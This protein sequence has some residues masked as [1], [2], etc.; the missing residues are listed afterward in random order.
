MYYEGDE[1]SFK[2]GSSYLFHC[3][4]PYVLVGKSSYDDRMVR[5]NVDGTWD[6]GDLRCEGPIC[7]DP[8]HPDEGETH[9][10]SVEESAVAKFTCNRPGFKPFPNDAINCTLG[11][12]SFC[13]NLKIFFRHVF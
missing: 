13:I 5:C 2:V 11:T 3:R 4:A 10:Q 9:L 6:L 8:G 1:N 7:A 12:V